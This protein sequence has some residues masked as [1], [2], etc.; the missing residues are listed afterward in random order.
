M[1]TW[2]ERMMAMGLEEDDHLSVKM[3]EGGGVGYVRIL[4]E[5]LKRVAWLPYTALGG[6]GS[7]RRSS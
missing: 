6:N 7:W 2:A 3:P 4:R 1:D 5:G